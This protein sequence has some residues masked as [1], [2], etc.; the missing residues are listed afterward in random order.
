MAAQPT[1]RS[2][3]PQH[4][5]PLAQISEGPDT[6]AAASIS[7]MRTV[8][9]EITWMVSQSCRRIAPSPSKV[10]KRHPSTPPSA[11][12][13]KFIVTASPRTSSGM[14]SSCSTNGNVRP[15]AATGVGQGALKPSRERSL[16]GRRTPSIHTQKQTLPQRFATKRCRL[17]RSLPA[18][19]VNTLSSITCSVIRSLQNHRKRKFHFLIC[20]FYTKTPISI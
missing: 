15:V 14:P 4:P 9:V 19:S 20:Q 16:T 11:P 1:P 6:I 5:G 8:A 3:P 12:K 2:P 7:E 13:T 10:A 17:R 18:A